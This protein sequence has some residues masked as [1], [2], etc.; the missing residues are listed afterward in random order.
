MLK[1]YDA[2]RE[3]VRDILTPYS[4]TEVK[5]ANK[6]MKKV[7]GDRLS[8]VKATDS[9]EYT[10]YILCEEDGEWELASFAWDFFYGDFE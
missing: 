6:E 8:Q 3:A 10:Y 2:T 7:F 9:C 1:T 4:M 5:W